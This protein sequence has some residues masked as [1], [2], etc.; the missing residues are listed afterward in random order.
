MIHAKRAICMF[1][2]EDFTLDDIT[3]KYMEQICGTL[4]QEVSKYQSL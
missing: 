2:M 1:S 4:F 3:W